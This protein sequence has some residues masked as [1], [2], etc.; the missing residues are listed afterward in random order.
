MIIDPKSPRIN[1]IELVSEPAT[2]KSKRIRGRKAAGLPDRRKAPSLVGQEFDKLRVIAEAGRNRHGHQLYRC[3]CSCGGESTVT[4]QKLVSK[5]PKQ[6]TTSC[7]CTKSKNF[8]SYHDKKARE[9]P[10]EILRE[11]FRLRVFYRYD[12]RTIGDRF[13]VSKATVDAAFRIAARAMMKTKWLPVIKHGLKHGHNYFAI[14]SRTGLDASAVGYIA[15]QL[16]Q[17]YGMPAQ[18]ADGCSNSQR[19]AA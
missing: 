3:A 5:D 18:S 12:A 14:A 4:R 11:I 2:K 15:K 16:R 1:L 17:G 7:G 6:R 19:R 10:A 8:V 9:L 13:K